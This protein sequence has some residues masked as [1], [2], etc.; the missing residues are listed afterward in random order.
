MPR[1]S[2]KGLT[3]AVTHSPA[4]GH[5]F[6]LHAMTNKDTLLI[7]LGSDS[8][9]L[10]KG[11]PIVVYAEDGPYGTASASVRLKAVFGSILIVDYDPV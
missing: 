3:L 2:R 10:P 8:I 5:T 4:N 9:P 6:P 11:T 1:T 7:R